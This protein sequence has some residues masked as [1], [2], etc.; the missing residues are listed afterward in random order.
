MSMW[1]RKRL[2]WG[3]MVS[4]GAG[5]L[6]G[7]IAHQPPGRLAIRVKPTDA[8]IF[9]DG[10]LVDGNAAF[11]ER[12]AGT[13]QLSFVRGYVPRDQK[14]RV[15]AGEVQRLDV[16][17]EASPDTGFE[18][19]SDPPGAL[20]WL[21]GRPL[22]GRYGSGP[23]ARTNFRVDR[24]AP[25]RHLLEIKGDPRF[26]EWRSYFDQELGKILKI[27][28]ELKPRQALVPSP[29]KPILPWPP[30]SSNVS[31]EQIAV[32]LQSHRSSLR[33]CYERALR[34]DD[35]LTRGGRIDTRV[36]VR[37]GG[38]VKAV[39]FT[40]PPD[41]EAALGPCM[42]GTIKHWRIPA[43][44]HEYETEFPVLLQGGN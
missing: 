13:F 19:T 28:A 37:R 44:G 24:I 15:E 8:K 41:L 4:M 39:T 36:A 30:P 35:R 22:T 43:Y 16:E 26:V 10:R 34:R 7:L 2:L 29:P 42:R 14:V 33:D 17:L 25:G 38:A 40:A 32:L 20:V 31:Q 27:H 21:D 23:Q 11:I 18:L 1:M 9:L 3:V 12:P 5:F 6:A